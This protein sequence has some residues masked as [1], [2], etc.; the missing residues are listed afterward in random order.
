MTVKTVVYLDSEKCGL[1]DSENC[2][3]NDSGNCGQN[4]WSK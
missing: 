3:L 2:G 1:N 4:V